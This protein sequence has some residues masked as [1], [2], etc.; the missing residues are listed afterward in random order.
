MQI[1]ELREYRNAIKELIK[2]YDDSK[3]ETK[4]KVLKK[5]NKNT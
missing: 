1:Y 5:D 4:V 3:E 2:K